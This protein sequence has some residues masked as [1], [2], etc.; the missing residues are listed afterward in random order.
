MIYDLILGQETAQL[1]DPLL[2]SV[3]FDGH[4]MYPG[5]AADHDFIHSVAFSPDGT[6]L[7]AGGYRV[8]KLWRHPHNVRKW[9]ASL[10]GKPT[11]LAVNRS[12]SLIAVATADK[13]IQLF[14]ATKGAKAHTLTGASAPITSLQ[15]SS[16]G[17]TLYAGSLDKSWRAW[18]VA[19]G[20]PG[21][22]V[23]T[24]A[25]VNAI[26]LNKAGTQLFTAGSDG[27]V[28]AW[29]LGPSKSP[30]KDIPVRELKGHTKAV[31][32][33]A[34][35]LPAGS[36]LISGSDDGSVR[37]W[38]L[39]TGK[40]LARM[41]HGGPVTAVA[42][43]PDGQVI[44]S[45][46]TDKFA[47]LWQLKNG[48]RI[49]EMKGDLN[50]ERLVKVRGEAQTVAAQHITTAQAHV[51]AAEQEIK[52]RQEGAKKTADAR[53]AGE[54][55]LSDAKTKEKAATDALAA[56][57]KTLKAKPTDAALKKKVDEATKA[58]TAAAEAT[59][60]ATSAL[61]SLGRAT[62]GAEKA[63]RIAND[64]LKEA[65]TETTVSE[66][67][68]KETDHLLAEAIAAATQ[69][70]RPI[71]ALAFSADGKV[72]A[73]AGD[74]PAVQL[75]DAR[76][77]RHWAAR[78]AT[79]RRS[80]AWPFSDPRRSSPRR[81]ISLSSHGTRIRPGASSAASAPRP[82]LRWIPV[83]HRCPAASSAW[84]LIPRERSW[85]PAAES[86]R[87]AA[88]LKSGT[89]PRLLLSANS[90]TH[91]AT[92]SLGSSS[93]PTANTWRAERPTSS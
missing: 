62:E 51:K 92:R 90:K 27:V 14:P 13:T 58:A 56:A 26:A 37:V 64:R 72:L 33:L 89:S 57:Q 74:D 79:R 60:T 43:R 50:A 34:V 7:A 61:V 32:S 8:V 10:S 87:G 78:Q 18:A 68:K 53:K 5:G 65:K 12:G 81:R 76:T 55:A 66:A 1:V 31:T 83:D 22:V 44:A 52:D 54:K 67:A 11:A 39:A 49:A 77:G 9:T 69:S 24:P 4:L 85:P 73:T 82:T 42:V 86:R 20:A 28:R 6:L 45:A 29:S 71:R 35:V 2:S 19:D 25:A 40:Q 23:S 75:W 91:I 47:R 80:A 48:R 21:R 63:L 70:L 88:S 30:G 3:Q 15:F 16:D 17:R 93:R 41:D 36:Q 59:K 38:D 84:H 46:G